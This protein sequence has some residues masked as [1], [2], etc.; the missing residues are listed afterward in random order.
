M[1]SKNLFV[2]VGLALTAVVTTSACS[3]AQPPAQKQTGQAAQ[4]VVATPEERQQYLNAARTSWNF[5]NSIYQPTT[6]FA[7]A[8]GTYDY[9]TLWDFAG[10]MAAHYVARD[11]GFIDNA[12]YDA[13]ISRALA[14]LSSI[15]LFDR[16]AFNRIYDSKTG[17]MVDNGGK[18]SPLGAGWSSTDMGRLLI[19]LRIISNRDPKYAQLAAQVVRRLDMNKVLKNGYLT[20]L[21]VDAKTRSRE[22]FIETEMGYQQYAASGFSMWGAKI[23][24]EA[25]DIRANAKAANVMGVRLLVDSRGNDRVMSE[26]YIMLGLELG[27]R[28]AELRQQAQRV[29]DAQ[30]ARYQKTGIVTAVT[31]DAMP[32]PPYY[33][34]YYSVYNRGQ[35]FT[36]EGPGDKLYVQNPRW[37]STKAAFGWNAVLP[38]TYSQ[39]LLRTVQPAQTALGWGSGVY[40]GTYKPTG[41]PSLNTAALIMESA[42]FKLK[43]IP[44][45]VD[46]MPTTQ[47]LYA[48]TAQPQPRPAAPTPTPV[49]NVPAK[50]AAAKKK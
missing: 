44:L 23:A 29:L 28:S 17:R 3:K 42:L 5:V 40:E 9:V 33:F 35:A 15:D 27:Y 43:G 14:T 48:Y 41:V 4:T 16:A 38:N 18:I 37:I 24:K 32:D 31:E 22:A 11:L 49:K 34:Y 1:Q 25:L 19:W 46:A 45:F 50:K 7:K 21:N 36:I 2:A 47:P 6:G 8:H 20:G 10:A 13:R 26:P 12:T 30:M 39:L